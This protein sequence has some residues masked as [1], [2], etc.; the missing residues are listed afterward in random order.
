[1]KPLGEFT[2]LNYYSRW[3][4]LIAAR[5][6]LNPR[7]VGKPKKERGTKCIIL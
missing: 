7:P 3:K 5:A 2:P 1:M 6:V 4:V